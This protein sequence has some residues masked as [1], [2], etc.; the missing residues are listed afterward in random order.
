[1]PGGDRTG[2]LGACKNLYIFLHLLPGGTYTANE[3]Q[4]KAIL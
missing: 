2:P 4:T 3:D 1:M